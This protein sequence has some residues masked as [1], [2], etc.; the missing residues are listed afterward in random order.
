MKHDDGWKLQRYMMRWLEEAAVPKVLHFEWMAEGI[1]SMSEANACRL[2]SGR[3]EEEQS[4]E[5]LSS[6]MELRIQLHPDIRIVRC[7]S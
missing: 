4:L 3:D 7:R 5:R 6:C 2:C 1:L